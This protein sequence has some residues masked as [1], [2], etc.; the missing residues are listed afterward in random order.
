M[1]TIYFVIFYTRMYY[2]LT[3]KEYS[4]LY[5]HAVR[6]TSVEICAGKE[7]NIIQVSP[8]INELIFLYIMAYLK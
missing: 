1:P 6:I 5:I 3:S 2:F 8:V 4:L 7:N